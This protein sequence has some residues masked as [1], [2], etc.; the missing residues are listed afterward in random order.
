MYV[1]THKHCCDQSTGKWTADP[2]PRKGICA[3]EPFIPTFTSCTTTACSTPPQSPAT[4]DLQKRIEDLCPT[5]PLPPTSQPQTSPSPSTSTAPLPPPTSSPQ[6]SAGCVGSRILNSTAGA[7]D[8]ATR[9]STCTAITP[10]EGVATIW[11]PSGGSIRFAI[12]VWFAVAA[13][14]W[15]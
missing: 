9:N 6:P 10:F 12:S 1:L 13:V 8:T 7:N 11:T 14:V 3:C 2:S 5:P 4:D 15:L